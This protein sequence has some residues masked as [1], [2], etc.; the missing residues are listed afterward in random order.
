LYDRNSQVISGLGSDNKEDE[1]ISPKIK[2]EEEK[3]EVLATYHDRLSDL[4]QAKK[5]EWRVQSTNGKGYTPTKRCSRIGYKCKT[6][7]YCK[8]CNAPFCYKLMG[9]VGEDEGEMSCF[10]EH[11]MNIKR[12]SK[13]RV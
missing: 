3:N 1:E 8:Q 11:F 5:Y 2:K 10:H 4:H 13:R 9:G 12:V 7:V 6:R